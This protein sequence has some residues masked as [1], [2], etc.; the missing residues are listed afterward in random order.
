MLLNA[1]IEIRQTSTDKPSL[2]NNSDALV[3]CPLALIAD[4][5]KTNLTLLLQM[6]VS[7]D[8]RLQMSAKTAI[9]FHGLK[10]K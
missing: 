2:M 3:L 7:F 9:I 10:V 4:F 6:P 5:P 1:R 8:D